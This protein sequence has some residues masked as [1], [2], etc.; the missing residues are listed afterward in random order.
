MASLHNIT[1]LSPSPSS[2]LSENST[3]GSAAYT[4]PILVKLGYA[5]NQAMASN[6]MRSCI[7]TRPVCQQSCH[8]APWLAQVSTSPQLPL[9]AHYESQPSMPP[10]HQPL[11]ALHGGGGG[12]GLHM[13]FQPLHQ[14]AVLCGTS[15]PSISSD[16]STV[17]RLKMV[18][19]P[20][21]LS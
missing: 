10:L 5:S 6:Q 20:G 21:L 8:K 16:S 1:G 11:E 2:Q 18:V 19:L 15:M 9:F 13:G 12:G 4:S 14:H 7:L 3:D 17:A